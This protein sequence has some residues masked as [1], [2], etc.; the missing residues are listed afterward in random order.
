MGDA[1]SQWGNANSRPPYNLSTSYYYH[2]NWSKMSESVLAQA[3][4][5]NFANGGRLFWEVK[6]TLNELD[7]NFHLSLI[8]LRQFFGQNQVISKKK[9]FTKI[10][11]VFPAEIRWSPKKR[12]K[13]F[14][15]IQSL[16]LTNFGWAPEHKKLHMSGPFNNKSFITVSPSQLLHPN[17]VGGGCFHFRRKNRPQKH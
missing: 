5:Q 10:E 1:K 9:I 14:T 17:P 16:L 4:S 7:P 12:K 6:T 2:R 15:E 11:T 8:R 13:V 3:R